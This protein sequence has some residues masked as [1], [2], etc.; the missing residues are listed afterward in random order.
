ME[1]SKKKIFLWTLY[2]FANSI[3]VV[4]FLLYFSQWLVVEH[5]VPDIWYNLMYTGSS[6]LLILTAPIAGIIA[7]KK[8]IRMPYLR[9]TTVL[10]FAT[11]AITSLLAMFTN[12]GSSFVL[13][14][15]LAYML[16]NY[17]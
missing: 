1:M 8:R 3:T 9:I 2:D 6:I 11:I 4:A 14:A 5:N 13:F 17:F 15:A 10:M 12:P 16:G 7:D